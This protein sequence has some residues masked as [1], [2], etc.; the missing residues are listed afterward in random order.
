MK[1]DLFLSNFEKLITDIKNR[2]P[3]LFVIT[4][5]FNPRS[6][7]RWS[8][9]IN[10]AEGTKL[11]PQTSLDGLQQPINEPSH[12]QKV[13]LL[14][15]ILFSQI[16]QTSLLIMELMHLYFQTVTIRLLMQVLIF[17]LPTHHH[18]NV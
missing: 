7:S 5:D 18:I 4:G 16:S 12:I 15:L 10:T 9:D 13:A 14:V 3:Y 17:I 8:N 11:F 6:F 1:N 2:K